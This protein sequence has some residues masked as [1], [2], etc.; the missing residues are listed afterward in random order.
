MKSFTIS[1][2][3]LAGFYID[4]VFI[5]QRA[6]E[7]S[8]ITLKHI[9]MGYLIAFAVAALLFLASFVVRSAE[10]VKTLR[11]WVLSSSNIQSF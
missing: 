6:D 1:A 4:H 3:L 8:R 11:L 5:W 7:G 10:A 9:T 2:A